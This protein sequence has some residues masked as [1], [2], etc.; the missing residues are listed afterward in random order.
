MSIQQPSL[1][2]LAYIARC[3]WHK[4]RCHVLQAY[5]AS[6]GQLAQAKQLIADL[7]QQDKAK[8]SELKGALKTAFGLQQQNEQLHQQLSCQ[9]EESRVAQQTLEQALADKTEAY[10]VRSKPW[11]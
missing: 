6:A 9:S 8:G 11:T 10:E 4:W 2:L 5:E 3:T 1:H 7:E